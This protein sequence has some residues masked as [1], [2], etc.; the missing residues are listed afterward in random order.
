[1]AKPEDWPIL[2]ET[3]L[4]ENPFIRMT[5][6]PHGKA[7]K[8]CE[9]PFTVYRWRPGAKARYKKTELCLTCAKLKNVCQTCVLDLQF[10]LPVQVRD[11]ALEETERTGM[12]GED[13]NREWAIE[14]A[15]RKVMMDGP[16]ASFGKV[17]KPSALLSKLSRKEPYYA[18]NLPHL[19]SFYAKGSCNRGTACPYRHEMPTTG[20]LANQNIKDRFYGNNDPV[21]KKMLGRARGGGEKLVP[22][23]DKSITTLWVGGIDDKTTE[24][25][26]RD[27]FYPFGEIQSIHLVS[28][29]LCAFVQFCDRIS[30]EEAAAKLH[31]S[32]TIRNSSLRI[33]WGKKA[34]KKEKAAPPGMSEHGASAASGSSNSNSK[35]NTNASAATASSTSSSSSSTSAASASGTYTYTPPQPLTS[36]SYYHAFINNQAPPPPPPRQAATVVPPPPGM[37]GSKPSYPSMDPRNMSA[38]LS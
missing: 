16:T 10:G 35:S 4:G 28:A 7:C 20:E 9:R 33:A 13:T 11:T 37:S 31:N 26:L 30:A 1:M 22:P 12:P 14:Q 8:I 25:E 18:R 5:K 2:C 6:E 24:T 34:D 38:R 3:C 36:T 19:C 29:K 15:E 23:E 32:L 21:A 17:A 27:K